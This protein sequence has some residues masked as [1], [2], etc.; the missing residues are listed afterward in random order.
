MGRKPK[1]IQEI[2]EKQASHILQQYKNKGMKRKTL[3]NDVD[4]L[5]ETIQQLQDKLNE[6]VKQ[7]NTFED[8]ETF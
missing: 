8:D 1:N 7:Q 2:D 5:R 4:S 3:S 6:L